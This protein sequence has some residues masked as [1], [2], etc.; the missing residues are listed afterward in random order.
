MISAFKNTKVMASIRL[1]A[2]RVSAF[3][4]KK[5][6]VNIQRR[7]I[8]GQIRQLDPV[9]YDPK[10]NRAN[11]TE[12][13]KL[14][15]QLANER[16]SAARQLKKEA[17]FMQNIKAHELG[18]AR[19]EKEKERKH[20]IRILDEADHNYRQMRT[21]NAGMDTSMAAHKERKEQKK[22]KRV[23]GDKMVQ[24]KSKPCGWRQD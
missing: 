22:S 5:P 12:K 20:H 24:K 2:D 17:A 18:D 4:G 16:R 3:A 10:Q 8:P 21:E 13:Q 19:E 14:Q 23:A 9:F 7:I 1:A 6:L 15:K 11:K